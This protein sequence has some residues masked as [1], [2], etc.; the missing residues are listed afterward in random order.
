MAGLLVMAACDRAELT[1]YSL[2]TAMK[3]QPSGDP[4]PLRDV[5]LTIDGRPV[6]ITPTDAVQIASALQRYLDAHKATQEGTPL[7]PAAGEPWVD[8]HNA[9][10]IG[11]WILGSRGDRLVLTLRAAPQPGAT[12]GYQF[13]GSVE[14][15]K[16]GW[17]V[18]SVGLSRIQYK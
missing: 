6:V 14:H 5:T 8:S 4:L 11:S 16:D 17:N 9:L 12:F 13:I 7:P 3:E 1:T 18:P 2:E 10:R 15:T